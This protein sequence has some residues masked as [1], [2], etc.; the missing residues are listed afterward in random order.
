VSRPAALAELGAAARRPIEEAVAMPPGL[1]TD[2]AVLALEEEQIFRREWI[3][4]G[5]DSSLAK[6]GDYLT[7]TIAG[8]PLFAVRGEDGRVRA[9]SNVCRHR[10][11]LLLAGTGNAKVVVCPYHAWSYDLTGRLRGA[12]HMARNQGFRREDYRLPEL[13]CETWE[14]WL[15]VSL[16]PAIEPVAER[17]R[18]LD[19]LIGRYRMG[20]YLESFR[21]EHDWDTNWKILAEN[22]MES[23]H[24][25]TLHRATV[26]PHSKVEE[27]E[28]PPG[29]AAFNYHW[30]T[31]EASLPIGN[32]HPDNRRLEGHWR[33][34][35]ALLTIYPTHLITLTPGYFW[36]LI[37]QPR[38]VGGVHIVYGGGM[39]PEFIADPGSHQ[40]LA[41]LKALLDRVNAEDR[42]G[43]EAVF[44]GAQSRLA[45]GGHLSHL[46]RPNQEFGRYLARRLG[47]LDGPPQ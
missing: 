3:C 29:G 39:A 8:E 37:L 6:A 32:A 44:R 12:P 30:I 18:P 26:G 14:G 17:L 1:Y 20:G 43:V 9:F 38:G 31:K 15:Y 25:P 16:D 36:Y 23:Y 34:T 7:A 13:R 22:F 19:A 5:R 28:C 24:L 27:M 10:M 11:S 41:T 45:R 33:K 35:T 40:H 4:L 42:S 21:E 46:E 2:P 47:A